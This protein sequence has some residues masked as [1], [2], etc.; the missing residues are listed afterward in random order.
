MPSTATRYD[1]LDLRYGDGRPAVLRHT[2]GSGF[3]YYA[4]G[5]K[6]V[7]LSANGQDGQ[8]R[9]RRFSAIIHD[10]TSRNGVVGVFD[11]WGIGY[12]DGMVSAGDSQPPKILIADKSITVIDGAGKASEVPRGQGRS[13]NVALR[14]NHYLTL[15]HSA[16]RTTLDFQCESVSHSFVVGELHGEEVQGM[17]L[18][19][20]LKPLPEE[21]TRLIGET[22]QKLDGVREKVSTLKVDPSQRDTKPAF[23]VNTASMKDVLE[24]LTSLQHSLSHPNLAPPDLQWGTESK[25]KKLLSAAHPQCPGQLAP[26]R[27]KWS[28]ARV[29]GKCTE[30]RLANAKATVNA[31]K[32]IAQ[33]SQL[34]IPELLAENASSGT[35]LVVVCLAAYSKEQSNYARLLAEKAHAELWAKFCS[36]PDSGPLPAKLV[37]VELTEIGGF[38]E[39]YGVKEIPYCLMFLGGQ[40][41]YSKR[42]RGIRM[43]PR[44]AAAAKPKVL[45][46]EPNPAQQLKLERALRRNG[47]CSDLALDAGQAVRLAS[48]SEGY[49][50]L[51][52]S[53]MLQANQLRATVAAAKRNQPGAVILGFDAAAPV[54]E[55]ASEERQRFLDECAYVFPFA[56]SYTGLA[57][58]LARFDVTAVDKGLASV[59]CNSHKKEFFD[60]VLGAL[61]RGG[62]TIVAGK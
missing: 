13:T 57:A 20:G 47:Y 14:I 29:S 1:V 40:Q 25:L 42:L 56:P 34:K 23:S 38:A 61:E 58:V 21:S 32:S 28:I 39:K 46:A 53:S 8:G 48:R 51:L 37:A 54:E 18:N 44:D 35:L 60:D 2:D 5:R 49:G 33:V 36:K 43:A 15:R 4:S 31:P 45:L 55:E 24:N 22:T 26:D 52:L 30:E 11:D 10:D 41:V 59:P 50:V 7:C 9:T 16:G 17:S 12:A 62:R 19:T 6:A 3:A 27:T